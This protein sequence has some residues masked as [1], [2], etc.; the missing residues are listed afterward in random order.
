[1]IKYAKTFG[2]SSHIALHGAII[3]NYRYKTRVLD[4]DNFYVANKDNY[5]GLVKAGQKDT[6]KLL[7]LQRPS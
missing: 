4:T 1:M 5:D 3:L 7:D 6:I 2:I